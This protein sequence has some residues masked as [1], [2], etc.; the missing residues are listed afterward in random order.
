MSGNMMAHMGSHGWGHMLIGG[1][2]MAAFW[3]AVITLIVFLVR[4]LTSRQSS[5]AS[6]RSPSALE[7]LQQRYARGEID[8][9]EY[10]ARRRDL[11]S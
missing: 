1:V 8:K 11:E 9:H 4:R 3:I 2:M 5:P 7:L 10:E 6:Q